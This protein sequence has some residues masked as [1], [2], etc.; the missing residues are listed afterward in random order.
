MDTSAWPCPS[1]LL[2][3]LGRKDQAE[4]RDRC[5]EPSG[6]TSGSRRPEGVSSSL[7]LPRGRAAREDQ[8]A[9]SSLDPR[10]LLT[11]RRAVPLSHEPTHPSLP[12]ECCWNSM[13]GLLSYLPAAAQAPCS[14][15]KNTENPKSCGRIR[16]NRIP[17]SPRLPFSLSLPSQHARLCRC[18]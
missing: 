13:E 5:L 18:A 8:A 3:T 2:H 17:R 7:H 11:P 10:G 4:P 12:M 6:W 16:A 9:G 15:R 1:V 14:D